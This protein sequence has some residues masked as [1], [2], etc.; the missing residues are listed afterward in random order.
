MSVPGFPALFYS[1]E[2][3]PTNTNLIKTEQDPKSKT[4]RMKWSTYVVDFEEKNSVSENKNVV[5]PYY[6]NDE[7]LLDCMDMEECYEISPTASGKF[8]TIFDVPSALLPVIVGPKGRKLR[9]LQEM[10]QTLIKVP[11]AHEVGAPVKITGQSERAVASARNQISILVLKKREKLPSTHFI[12]IPVDSD[13]IRNNFALFKK[14]VLKDKATRG[15][16][17]S[18]F[19]NPNKLHIT[20]EVLTLLDESEIKR[21]KDMFLYNVQGLISCYLKEKQY[22]IRLQGIEIMNDDP[23][24]VDVLYGKVRMDNQDDND[25]FQRA[26]DK[27]SNMYHVYG[28]VRKHYDIKLHVTLMNSLFRQDEKEKRTTFDASFILEKYRKFD[29][30]TAVLKSVDLS[31]RFTTGK[32]G[33]YK[34]EVSVP[35]EGSS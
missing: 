18:I 4:P 17:E 26:I 24:E 27:I 1:K 3:L 2:P 7:D 34:Y 22:K 32:N 8:I 35:F 21:A 10:T 25:N 13:E 16:D 9:E 29:F 30:G 15:V 19:Q 11:R 12:S 28:Y 31:V 6:D 23:S 20:I 14:I 33:Y 5:A